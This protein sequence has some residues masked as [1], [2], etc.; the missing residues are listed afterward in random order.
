M[1]AD[2][3]KSKETPKADEAAQAKSASAGKPWLKY[4][5][6]GIGGLVAVAAIAFGTLMLA[7]GVSE[8][9]STGQESAEG[10]TAVDKPQPSDSHIPP[11][12]ADTSMNLDSLAALIANDTSLSF[13]EQGQAAFE[14]IVSNLE[15]LDH[16]PAE[17]MPSDDAALITSDD[18]AK[19][20]DWV[21]QE[22]ARLAA[23]AGELDAR[24]K[25]L[26]VRE[27]KIQQG[28]ARIEQAESSRITKLAGLYDNMEASAVAK[29]LANLDDETV[30]AIVPRMKPKNA[31]AV[32]A[33]MPPARAA[34]L[35]KEMVSIADD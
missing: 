20:T 34:K 10:Q 24:E 8:S 2:T 28:I 3:D 30:V 23:R 33:L 14:S 17:T 9:A 27:T 31:S 22:E 7:G 29:L 32:L 15:A 4:L 13:L 26:N 12:A 35:S 21:K 6:L 25:Q 19:K 18:L 1:V 11:A 16:A 5:L